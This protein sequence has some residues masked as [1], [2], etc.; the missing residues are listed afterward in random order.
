MYSVLIEG[1]YAH[2]CFINLRSLQSGY[3]IYQPALVICFAGISQSIPGSH[4]F[5]SLFHFW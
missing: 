5:M 2:H 4:A 1:E 3:L